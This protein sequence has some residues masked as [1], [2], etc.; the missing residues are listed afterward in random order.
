MYKKG[1]FIKFHVEGKEL[2]SSYPPIYGKI[3]EV[4]PYK[5][6]EQEIIVNTKNLTV[7]LY[8]TVDIIEILD[9]DEMQFRLMI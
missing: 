2:L 1:Q 7:S 8:T 9:I 5:R 4:R 3:F 6:N